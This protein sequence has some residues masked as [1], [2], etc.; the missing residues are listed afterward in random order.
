MHHYCSEGRVTETLTRRLPC[1]EADGV[2]DGSQSECILVFGDKHGSV[3]QLVEG[4]VQGGLDMDEDA[5]FTRQPDASWHCNEW[6]RGDSDA[7]IEMLPSMYGGSEAGTVD[8]VADD[9]ACENMHSFAVKEVGTGDGK[10]QDDPELELAGADR[11]GM[12]VIAPLVTD[13]TSDWF[14]A[15][16]EAESGTTM[17]GLAD[18]WWQEFE[19]ARLLR[20]WAWSPL[21]GSAAPVGLAPVESVKRQ[22][23]GGRDVVDGF[24]AAPA[25]CS[26]IV[27]GRRTTPSR[28]KHAKL[29]GSQLDCMNRLVYFMWLVLEPVFKRLPAQNERTRSSKHFSKHGMHKRIFKRL[30]DVG[31]CETRME[32]GQE[33]TMLRYDAVK[34]VV[35]E[36][37]MYLSGQ[38]K[39]PRYAEHAEYRI[40]V[41]DGVVMSFLE[42]WEVERLVYHVLVAYMNTEDLNFEAA[43]RLLTQRGWNCV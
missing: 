25:P 5:A 9:A 16:F 37:F 40:V 43:K 19:R 1:D 3:L 6:A 18:G 13:V 2:S 22:S 8:A 35:R 12:P 38:Q 39:P 31:G 10:L 30:L 21:L 20:G 4:V 26:R 28:L 7:E 24:V 14:G 15:S 42:D 11:T 41:S 33:V 29:S 36:E 23:G 32:D 34:I 17:N 27:S